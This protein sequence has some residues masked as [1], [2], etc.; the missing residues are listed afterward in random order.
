MFVMCQWKCLFLTT[1][2]YSVLEIKLL[3]I[4]VV[5]IY[6]TVKC[7]HVTVCWISEWSR[8]SI[9]ISVVQNWCSRKKDLR[10]RIYDL[11]FV[12]V[13][14]PLDVHKVLKDF[15][16]GVSPLAVFR[17][18]GKMFRTPGK[19]FSLFFASTWKASTAAESR[20]LVFFSVSNIPHSSCIAD[21]DD[22]TAHIEAFKNPH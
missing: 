17:K 11:L 12:R 14:T 16:N 7:L 1:F 5:E 19:V 4:V 10:H 21:T 6:M 13:L 15:T 18:S 9:N 22:V 8:K 3:I 20:I 2:D